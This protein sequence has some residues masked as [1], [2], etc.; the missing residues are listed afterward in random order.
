MAPGQLVLADTLLKWMTDSVWSK[1]MTE[2]FFKS[3]MS[4]GM[5]FF[6]CAGE[7]LSCE[8][9]FCSNQPSRFSQFCMLVM[10]LSSSE[11]LRKLDE[12]RFTAL[13]EHSNRSDF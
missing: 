8:M 9:K 1:M 11:A 5:K 6:M 7:D 13:F 2:R 12:S 3:S 10:L 4:T